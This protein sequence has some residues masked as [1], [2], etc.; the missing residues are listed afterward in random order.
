MSDE[1]IAN[2]TNVFHGVFL[3][4]K[5]QQRLKEEGRFKYT[6]RDPEMSHPERITV[7]M[8][9]VGEAAR[10]VLELGDLANDKHN[11]NLR[12]EL[13]QVAAVA[14]SWVEGM[15]ERDSQ[16]ILPLDA[17][18]AYPQSLIDLADGLP[19]YVDTNSSPEQIRAVLGNSRYGK[20]V[21]GHTKNHEGAC[22]SKN[23]SWD[24]SSGMEDMTV[25]GRL[26]AEVLDAERDAKREYERID[27]WRHVTGCV[28]L[29][30]HSGD[31]VT[32]GAARLPPLADDAPAP[33][34][35]AD[36]DPLSLTIHAQDSKYIFFIPKGDYKIHVLRYGNP[37]L[38]ISSGHKAILALM[39]EVDDARK[40][41]KERDDFIAKYATSLPNGDVLWNAIEEEIAAP[42]SIEEDE[43]AAHLPAAIDWLDRNSIARH[44]ETVDLAWDLAALLR[45]ASL[46][47]A[48]AKVATDMKSVIT[49]FELQ[50]LRLI[51]DSLR[52]MLRGVIQIW[53]AAPSD[54]DG[55]GQLLH[56]CANRIEDILN[57]LPSAPQEPTGTCSVPGCILDSEHDGQCVSCHVGG[58]AFQKSSPLIAS[59]PCYQCGAV[60]PDPC[61]DVQ[62]IPMDEQHPVRSYYV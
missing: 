24:G 48:P 17:V 25:N 7:L 3:E 36:A 61:T 54:I 10:A 50:N 6:C 11:A 26:M 28:K 15:D 57:Q 33:Q 23:R 27:P 32:W 41:V 62:S 38:E 2:R 34:E 51:Y 52:T 19:H 20:V 47:A 5:R 9:E 16:L 55:Q 56:A 39:Y 29:P 40:L 13:I 12:K 21:E 53:R 8:E 58:S 42:E 4:M 49:T 31:C 59:K 18:S 43:V 14:L 60:D 1:Q 45:L 46:R 30:D 22:R 35:P 44:R 37:W